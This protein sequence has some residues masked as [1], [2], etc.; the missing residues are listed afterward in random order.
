MSRR[1]FDNFDV[2]WLYMDCAR[3]R[4]L[5]KIE[6]TIDT[7]RNMRYDVLVGALFYTQFSILNVLQKENHYIYK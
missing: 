5:F 6:K 7:L 1:R 2:Y 3:S 4:F